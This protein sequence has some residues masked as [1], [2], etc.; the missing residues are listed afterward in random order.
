[1]FCLY[2]SLFFAIMLL[3]CVVIAAPVLDVEP[4][5]VLSIVDQ[6]RADGSGVVGRVLLQTT[7]EPTGEESVGAR[8]L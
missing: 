3:T 1:M 2:R 4:Q 5:R 6:E 7:A 8:V